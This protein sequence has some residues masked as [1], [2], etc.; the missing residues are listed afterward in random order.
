MIHELQHL[1][2]DVEGLP[3]GGMGFTL[4]DYQK[5]SDEFVK[6]L[7]EIDRNIR[8]GLD[9]GTYNIRNLSQANPQSENG[10]I[11]QA[12]NMARDDILSKNN[13][14]I[15]MRSRAMVYP[16]P[17]NEGAKMDPN[18]LSMREEVLARAREIMTGRYRDAV[19]KQQKVMNKKIEY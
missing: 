9:Q 8:T 19:Q 17:M 15:N 4:T 7:D 5:I 12:L 14:P 13:M 11:Y 18:N 6:R 10:R 2:Q 16:G 3:Q 1:L